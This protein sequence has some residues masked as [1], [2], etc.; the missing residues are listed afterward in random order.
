LPPFPPS[1]SYIGFDAVATS[2]EEVNNPQRNLPLGILGAL[3]VVTLCYILLSLA[4]VMMVA[5]SALE[6]S[7]SFAAAFTYVGM[8]WA[9]HIVA[10]GE[11]QG[12]PG[13]G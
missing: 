12:S 7:G 11:F 1:R 8:P 5:I 6:K 9:Q 10:L 2:A 4:L 3:S 13:A